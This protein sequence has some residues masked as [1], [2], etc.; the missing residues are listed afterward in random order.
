MSE[1]Q[2]LDVR[3][4]RRSST[5]RAGSW[6]SASPLFCSGC[7]RSCRSVAATVISAVLRWLLLFAAGIEVVQAIYGGKWAGLF[8]QWLSAALFECSA[9]SSYGGAWSQLKF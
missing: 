6:P 2:A 1:I 3:I 9:L 5:T 8:Q 7:S 4:R